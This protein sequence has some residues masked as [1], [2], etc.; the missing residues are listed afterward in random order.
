MKQITVN[1][2]GQ[3]T[4][5]IGSGILPRIGEM[6]RQ[7]TKAQKVCLVS[8]SNVAPL[9]G[10]QVILALREAGLEVFQFT[11][12]AGETSKNHY[13][14]IRLLNFMTDHKLDRNDCVVALGGGVTGDLSGFAAATYLRGIAYI[15][16][17]TSL[18]AMVDSAVGGKTGINLS[19]GK[20]LCGAFWQPAAVLCD[21]DCLDSLPHCEFVNGCAEIIKYAVAF[22]PQLFFHLEERDTAFDRLQVISRCIEIKRDIVSADERETGKRRL[23]NLGHTLG[24]SIEKCSKYTIAHGYA[25]AIG[26]AIVARASNCPDAQRIIALL[27]AFGLPDSVHFQANQI[28]AKALTDKKRSGEDILLVIPKAI[29]ECTIVP[30]PVKKLK[31]FIEAGL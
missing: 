15:Q 22:D 24:H 5:S 28:R 16:A 10:G 2:S 11:F 14:Y 30:T 3:Y 19:A 6:V 31:S 9:Y 1:T 4:V 7:T 18:L 17:P 21:I 8:D 23:L 13:T 27:S 26:M 25:V 29:G 20:N 12:T